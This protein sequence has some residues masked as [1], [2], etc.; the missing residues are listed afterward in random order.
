MRKNPFIFMLAQ[1]IA[2]FIIGAP[3]NRR[4]YC[5][6][7]G[8]I[9]GTYQDYMRT[10]HWKLVKERYKRKHKYMCVECG[11]REKGLHLHH[12]TYERIGQERDSDLI[13]LCQ[14]CHVMEHKRLRRVKNTC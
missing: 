9:A 11:S 3:G 1:R 13:Y 5:K 6:D 12:K 4:I 8:E 7:T 10:R 14:G 2:R